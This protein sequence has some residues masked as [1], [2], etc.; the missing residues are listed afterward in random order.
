MTLQYVNTTIQTTA[1]GAA[2]YTLAS[3]DD[4]FVGTG[5]RLLGLG[6]A[7]YG[8]LVTGSGVDV[9]LDGLA[10]GVRAGVS[11]SAGATDL[12]VNGSAEAVGTGV[13]V[14]GSNDRVFIAASGRVTGEVGVAQDGSG[15][16][17]Q[18]F[19]A[20]S[21]E[22]STDG[23]RLG[24]QG[25]LVNTGEIIAAGNGVS[26]EGDISVFTNTGSI[27]GGFAGVRMGASGVLR[28]TGVISGGIHAT[29]DNL[30]AWELKNS[31]EVIGDIAG[32]GEVTTIRN[33]GLIDGP[34]DTGGGQRRRAEY[35]R[36]H[37]SHQPGS[38]QRLRKGR[39]RRRRAVRRGR[40][41][42]APRRRRRRHDRRR[43]SGRPHLRRRGR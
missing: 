43:P 32:G 16:G 27:A 1:L 34:V 31:G 23:V 14:E 21:I 22:A 24:A 8:L 18:L 36:H 4:L 26:I 17:L 2:A 42:P 28:N 13:L 5:G 30:A 12:H 7:G 20:G 19:N 11:L 6:T 38:R 29:F 10:F 40:R 3:P 25:R 41:R 15:A 35:G 9:L 39:R 33:T 37:R